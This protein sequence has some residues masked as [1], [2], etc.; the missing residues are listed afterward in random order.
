MILLAL[1]SL[2]VGLTLREVSQF[3][4]GFYFQD[5]ALQAKPDF[6]KVICIHLQDLMGLYIIIVIYL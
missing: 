3:Q 1:E 6:P 4:D 2:I 5:L